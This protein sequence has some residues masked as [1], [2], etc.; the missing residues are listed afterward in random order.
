MLPMG[1]ADLVICAF[2]IWLNLLLLI[3]CNCST[4]AVSKALTALVLLAT[5]DIDSYVAT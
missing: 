1:G 4:S 2:L 5:C 3:N